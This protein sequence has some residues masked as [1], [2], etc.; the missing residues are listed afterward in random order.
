[1]KQQGESLLWTLS[2]TAIWLNRAELR[3]TEIHWPGLTKWAERPPG[4]L[5]PKTTSPLA[6]HNS[7]F[8]NDYFSEFIKLV[9]V[10]VCACVRACMHAC[11]RACVRACMCVCMPVFVCVCVCARHFKKIYKQYT[12][13]T[14]HIYKK[15]FRVEQTVALQTM[16]ALCVS[17]R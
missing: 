9:C 8:C 13:F 5:R 17:I 14:V 7:A 12:L 1:M 6:S 2:E 16:T 3:T 11:V 4:K 15:G 10:C